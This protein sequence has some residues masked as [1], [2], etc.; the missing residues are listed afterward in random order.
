MITIYQIEIYT[1]NGK[2]G[3]GILWIVQAFTEIVRNNEA[4]YLC[5]GSDWA[6]GSIPEILGLGDTNTNLVQLLPNGL[7]WR[8]SLQRNPFAV[9]SRYYQCP[10][11]LET[12][13]IVFN[14]VTFNLIT[15]I[16]DSNLC[17]QS[18]IQL[19]ESC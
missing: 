10:K 11:L 4:N 18:R 5:V 6:Y 8:G 7:H 14:V 17:K 15:E 19:G 2:G 9:Y 12:E 3:K 16:I 13:T 1:V